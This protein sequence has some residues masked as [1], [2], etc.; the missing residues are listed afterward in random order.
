MNYI[1][2][3]DKVKTIIPNKSRLNILLVILRLPY[4]MA[5]WCVP[6]IGIAY[7][8]SS[9]KK[10]G[11]NTYTLNLVE[12]VGDVSTIIEKSIVQNDIDIIAC[13]ALPS[14][15]AIKEANT[16]FKIARNIKKDIITCIGGGL[17]T[18]SP[19]EAMLNVSADIGVH[20]EGE[21]TT[22]EMM[23]TLENG[24]DLREVQSLILRDIDGNF[25]FNPIRP[26]IEVLDQLPWPDWDGFKFFNKVDVYEK[27]NYKH[28]VIA[29]PLVTSRGCPFSCTFCS[30]PSGKK[31]RQRSLDSIFSEID[32]LVKNYGVNRVFFDDDLFA[33]KSDY[34]I[35]F[36]NR[37]K[38]YNIEW[39]LYL[40]VGENMTR[41]LLQLMYE[42][43]CCEIYYGIESG[44]D[45]ILKNMQ[46]GIDAKTIEDTVKLTHEAGIRVMGSF[47]LGDQM[48]TMQTIRNTFDFAERISDKFTNIV[49]NPLFLYPGSDLY[50]LAVA[51]GEIKDTAQFIKEGCPL[52]N[53][54]KLSDDEYERLIKEII[55]QKRM[56]RMLKQ[57]EQQKPL[58]LIPIED[59]TGFEAIVKCEKC[60]SEDKVFFPISNIAFYTRHSCP[61]CCEKKDSIILKSYTN[62]VEERLRAL[63]NQK[64]V[65]FW[66]YG[67]FFKYFSMFSDTMKTEKY[68]IV[69]QNTQLIGQEFYGN[70]INGVEILCKKTVKVVIVSAVDHFEEISKSI[71]KEYSHIKE[72]YS[73]KELGFK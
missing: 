72:I 46:K 5:D 64:S 55:P 32:Y 44:D 17:V 71:R 68:L 49:Y 22:C 15:S 1:E 3:Q 43:G 19:K 52:T 57:I 16:L 25:I 54:S 2:I 33:D 66:G 38:K 53:I 6:P 42:S 30:K 23:M 36:C 27:N 61:V 40:R 18:S 67:N 29:A 10:Q 14:I 34:L 70:K 58:N 69:D 21:I 65:A 41:K 37:I 59:R 9:L 51:K 12:E 73:L 7:V 56:E 28:K 11:F 50:K 60:G 26:Y 20:G 45:T 62:L 48:E 39:L 47:I 63:I 35:E 31:Y 24:G 4:Q 8:S 13:G